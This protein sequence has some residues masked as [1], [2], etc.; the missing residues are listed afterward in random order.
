[1]KDNINNLTKRVLEISYKNKLSHLGSCLTALPIIDAIYSMKGEE[2]RFVL[3]GFSEQ[4]RAAN[5]ERLTVIAALL[6]RF[7]QT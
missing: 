5:N 4:L 1:M 6:Q 7:I 2:D 3:L